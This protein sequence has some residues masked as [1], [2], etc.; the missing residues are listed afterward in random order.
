MQRARPITNSVCVA[1]KCHFYSTHA[2]CPLDASTASLEIDWLL[3]E[4]NE[5]WSWVVLCSDT[6]CETRPGS[7]PSRLEAGTHCRT[8]RTMPGLVF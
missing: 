5:P 3:W 8:H 7:G 1:S 6:A 2:S 4:S